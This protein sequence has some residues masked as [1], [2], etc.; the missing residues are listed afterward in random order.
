[1]H[2]RASAIRLN[3]RDKPCLKARLRTCGGDAFLHR[4]Y[5]GDALIGVNLVNLR[6]DSRNQERG[7]VEVRITRDA[8][9]NGS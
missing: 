9:E 3:A 8:K 6:F 5:L 2:A 7:S 4:L 1:M